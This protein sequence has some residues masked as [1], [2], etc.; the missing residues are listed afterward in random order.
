MDHS[1]VTAG[2]Q[3]N[4]S[5]CL[6]IRVRKT[7][8]FRWTLVLL[9]IIVV[10]GI[11]GLALRA[12]DRQRQA[13]RTGVQKDFEA[14]RWGPPVFQD[15]EVAKAIARDSLDLYDWGYAPYYGWA[16][17]PGQA[18]ETI[19]INSQGYRGPELRPDTGQVRVLLLG[20]SVAWGFGA[21]SEEH[22]LRGCLERELQR[23]FPERDWEVICLAEL[24]FILRQGRIRFDLEGLATG[25]SYA[26]FIDGVNDVSWSLRG[27][28]IGDHELADRWRRQLRLSRRRQRD[29]PPAPSRRESLYHSVTSFIMRSRAARLANQVR[30]AWQG[31][32]EQEEQDD[33]RSQAWAGRIDSDELLAYFTNECDRIDGIADRHGINVAMVLQPSLFMR[34]APSDHES[35]L[36]TYLAERRSEHFLEEVVGAYKVLRRFYDQGTRGNLRFLDHSDLFA[37][38]GTVFF[39][40]AHVSDCGNEQWARL[41]VDQLADHG[42]WRKASVSR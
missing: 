37:D 30:H 8:L 6:C 25:A 1:D 40:E 7:T 24:G 3:T 38:E 42:W 16:A 27:A 28:K 20:G 36:M 33:G 17:Q 14:L 9:T 15:A 18:M 29:A 5:D 19:S 21:T 41:L 32:T 10:E 26:I 31:R 13:A 11:S 34:S 39:D 23:R 35:R 12:I 4:G 2:R 22:T